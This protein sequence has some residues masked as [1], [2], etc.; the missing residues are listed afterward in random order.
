MTQ[1]AKREESLVPILFAFPIYDSRKVCGSSIVEVTSGR[2]E[3]CLRL[4]SQAN[5]R[6]D[7]DSTRA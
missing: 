3:L 7:L 1:F 4:S 6:A 2:E 5:L